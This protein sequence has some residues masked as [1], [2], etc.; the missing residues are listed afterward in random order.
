[1]NSINI[2]SHKITDIIEVIDGIAFQTN[3]LALN[4]AVE[5]ARA[6]EQGRG[7]AVV[8]S[9]VRD[10]A[11]RCKTASR[12]IKVLV[13]DTLE[14]VESGTRLVGE[15]G[16]TLTGIVQAVTRVNDIVAEI[17]VASLE[18]SQG[19]NQVNKALLQMDEMTQ[20]NATLTE[21]AAIASESMSLQAIELSELVE[22]FKLE[23]DS[24]AEDYTTTANEEVTAQTTR[25]TRQN[26]EDDLITGRN[27]D[28][29]SRHYTSY[30]GILK[31]AA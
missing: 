29:D 2:A 4:A 11:G 27:D 30:K 17:A 1:M 25:S 23:K 20:Q 6:G 26:A 8:A 22:Y 15:S 9:E 12:E 3:L 21:Q 24:I 31:S 5:A 19:I 10:L 13:E 28:S 7:F 14:K 18:Q 16:Q